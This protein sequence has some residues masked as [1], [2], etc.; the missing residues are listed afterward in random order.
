MTAPISFNSVT[1]SLKSCM[2]VSALAAL[3]PLDA[4]TPHS[5]A[6]AST[7]VVILEPFDVNATGT[8][9]YVAPNSISGTAMNALLKDVPMTINVVT[10]D[11]LEDSLV[12]SFERALDYN[13]SIVQTT[14]SENSNRVGLM[15]IRGFRN[16]NLLLDGVLASDFLPTQLIERI[17][18]VKGP[19]T[20]YGQSDPGGLVNVISKRPRGQN[21]GRPSRRQSDVRTSR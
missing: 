6:P 11:F 9:R 7:N 5:A 18:V 3:T 20:L 1:A 19:N 21:G 16:R 10:S 13:S 8:R 15:S 2:L 17:E 14:R 12:G 4:Q